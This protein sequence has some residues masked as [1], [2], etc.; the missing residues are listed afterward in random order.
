MKNPILTATHNNA[1]HNNNAQRYSEI[2]NQ[3]LQQSQFNR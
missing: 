2:N 3:H 1:I